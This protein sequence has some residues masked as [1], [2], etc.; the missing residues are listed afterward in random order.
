MAETGTTKVV[1]PKRWRRWIRRLL[2]LVLLLVGGYYVL[3]QSF[4]TRWIVM[5]QV[6]RLTGGRAT[7]SQVILSPSGRIV[8]RDGKLQAPGIP[9]EAGTVFSVKRL[10][11]EFDWSSLLGGGL[12]V[13]KIRLDEPLARV[14]QSVDD[15][16]VN[17]AALSPR[18]ATR[19]PREVP[20]VIV[21]GGVIEL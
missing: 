19:P 20:K 9:G 13:H 8:I 14:S 17:I 6:G 16:T 2:I 21:N 1:K 3:M 18:K 7:A 15:G 11:A 12:A 10:E 5:G 4:V